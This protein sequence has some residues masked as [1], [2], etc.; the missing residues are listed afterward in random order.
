MEPK[1]TPAALALLKEW[2]TWLVALQTG[3]IA[4]VTFLAGKEGAFKLDARWARWA[5]FC[6]AGS[7]FFATWALA[8]LPSIRLRMCEASDNF[9]NMGAFEWPPFKWLPLWVFTSAQ[10][11]LFVSGILLFMK[12]ITN[13]L[14]SD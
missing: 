14:K 13:R 10:H 6:F 9:Y 5:V 11:W 12:S 3:V 1:D 8:A 4:L 2:C 7:I